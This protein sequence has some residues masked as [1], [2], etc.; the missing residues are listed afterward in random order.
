[1]PEVV[2]C[3]EELLQKYNGSDSLFLSCELMKILLDMKVGDPASYAPMADTAA[4]TAEGKREGLQAR[5]YLEVLARWYARGKDIAKEQSVWLRYAETY[6]QEAEDALS[7]PTPSYGVA[8][9]FLQ[10]AIEALRN[11]VPGSGERQQELHHLLL[12][13]QQK[14]VAELKSTSVSTD[15]TELVDH[16]EQAVRDRSLLDALLALACLVTLPSKQHLREQAEQHANDSIW[17]LFPRVMLND[18]GK[19]VARQPGLYG[20]RKEEEAS[21]QAEVLHSAILHYSL[22]AQGTILPAI[23]QIIREHV[24]TIGDFLHLVQDNPFVPPGRE[25]IVARGLHAGMMG[26]FL[27]STHLLVPQVEHAIRTLAQRVGVI[28]SSLT[29]VG[30]QDELS[31]NDLL[32]KPE[33]AQIFNEDTLF[34]LQDLL[35]EHHGANLRNLVAHGLLDHDSFYS[36]AAVY[37]WWLVLW[38]CCIP[39]MNGIYQE[40]SARKQTADASGPPHPSSDLPADTSPEEKPAQETL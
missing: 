24:V 28:T 20:S 27:V 6:V 26:D 9:H 40:L 5:A 17:R 39:V 15:I 33:L 31:L 38:L 1:M 3:I 4:A 14:A 32:E 10:E 36:G 19:V 13:Y 30:I 11:R 7:R 2:E 35:V 21:L 23:G 34:T 37:L 29:S 18:Q 12:E 25:M 8:A 16:A 22:S